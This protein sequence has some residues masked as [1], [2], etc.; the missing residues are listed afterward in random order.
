MDCS[1]LEDMLGQVQHRQQR[2]IAA[3]HNNSSSQQRR[4][5]TSHPMSST[6]LK[7]VKF[8]ILVF[9]LC[10]VHCTAG[11]FTVKDARNKHKKISNCLSYGHSCWGG[12]GKRSDNAVNTP[13]VAGSFLPENAHNMLLIARLLR[14]VASQGGQAKSNHYEGLL[15]VKTLLPFMGDQDDVR[16]WNEVDDAGQWK[17]EMM[18]EQ[19]GGN[20]GV[21]ESLGDI[22]KGLGESNNSDVMDNYSLENG[23]NVNPYLARFP[24]TPMELLNFRYLLKKHLAKDN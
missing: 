11:R 7:F 21:E 22:G 3:D 10:S 23:N 17:G 16:Q 1:K 6:A 8:S 15:H 5:T 19:G 14:G 24:L 20:R 2:S 12:H 13:N 9:L 4:R 18:M